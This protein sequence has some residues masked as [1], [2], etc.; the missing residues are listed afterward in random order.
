MCSVYG[1]Y[2]EGNF[3]LATQPCGGLLFNDI[4]QLAPHTLHPHKMPVD[5]IS[6]AIHS[7]IMVNTLKLLYHMYF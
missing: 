2:W 1:S 3:Q 7:Q 6:D 5:I 4:T